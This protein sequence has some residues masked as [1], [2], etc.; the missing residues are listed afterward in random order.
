[1]SSIPSPDSLSLVLFARQT[2]PRWLYNGYQWLQSS[3]LRSQGRGETG[4]E[5][6]QC[7]SPPPGVTTEVAPGQ[8][9]DAEPLTEQVLVSQQTDSPRA[10]NFQLPGSS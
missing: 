10:M 6:V 8:G 9:Q 4:P 7:T 1:M 5:V 3:M 2:F